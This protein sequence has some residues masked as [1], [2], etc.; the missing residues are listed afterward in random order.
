MTPR[1]HFKGQSVT[2]F[3]ATIAASCENFVKHI[4]VNT[5]CGRNAELLMFIAVHVIALRFEVLVSSTPPEYLTSRYSHRNGSHPSSTVQ[6]M[7]TESLE[8]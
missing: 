1:L 6:F 7:Q 5:L 4:L 3:W 8:Y 2:L